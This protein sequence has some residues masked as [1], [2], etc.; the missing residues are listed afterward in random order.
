MKVDFKSMVNRLLGKAGIKI[1][2]TSYLDEQ[3]G[4]Y[5]NVLKALLSVTDNFNII[6][7]GANDG[8]FNDPIYDIVKQNKFSTNIILVEPQSE[9]MPML[10]ANYSYHPSVEIYNKAIGKDQSSIELY[11]IQEEYWD[12]INPDYA[13]DW[14]DYRA[15]TGLTTSNKSQLLDYISKHVSP[16]LRQ[17]SLIERYDVDIVQPQTILRYSDIMKEV[18]LLQV[19]SEGMD[20]EIVYSFIDDEIMPNIINIERTHLTEDERKQYNSKLSH[21]GYESLNYTSEETLSIK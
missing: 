1:D 2:Y 15:A 4:L 3:P 21:Y 16:E 5:R 8:K 14:P 20:D 10:K 9:I 19:D 12:Q 11:R 7:V 18:H 13:K 17:E 6:Q